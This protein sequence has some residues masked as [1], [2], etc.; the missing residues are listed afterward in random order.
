MEVKKSAFLK[1]T[2]TFGAI[3][4]MGFIII[5]VIFY[6]LGIESQNISQIVNYLVIIAGIFIGT[7]TFRDKF[8]YGSITYGKALGSGVLISLFSSIILAFYTYIFFKIIDPGALGKIYEIME[9]NMMKQGNMT[10]Q[11]LEMALEMAKKFTTPVTIAVGV[12]ISFVFWG[13]LFSLIT[14]FFLKKKSNPFDEA[15]KEVS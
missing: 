8:N 12:I 10:D 7:R 13:F 11:Q 1:N 4:G 3:T 9:Q 14:S 6:L 15:M 5:S 2:M